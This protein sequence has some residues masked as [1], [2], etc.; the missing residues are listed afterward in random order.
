MDQ[1]PCNPNTN[2]SESRDGQSI[3]ILECTNLV[4]ERLDQLET[5]VSRAF[6]QPLITESA[7]GLS[8][9]APLANLFESI[10]LMR[11]GSLTNIQMAQ[12]V[13]E[14]IFYLDRATKWNV[15]RQSTQRCHAFKLANL[16]R[17]Y[18][19]LQATKAS[20]EYQES[21]ARITV[22]EFERQFPR[23]GMTAR[24]FFSK[25]EEVSDQEYM[26]IQRAFLTKRI[27]SLPGPLP[28]DPSRRT[29]TPAA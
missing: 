13:D 4:I 1:N 12:G 24:R 25:L 7:P 18:W 23:L 29:R 28:A 14:I 5:R 9:P 16:L 26:R 6:G 15:R 10:T 17:A 19:L 11:Y 3:L 21:S 2:P 27:E 22:A 8:V 20:D